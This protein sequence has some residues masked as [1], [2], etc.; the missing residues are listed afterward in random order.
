M[1][2]FKGHVSILKILILFGIISFIAG[3]NDDLEEIIDFESKSNYELSHLSSNDI[4]EI[5]ASIGNY[6]EKSESKLRTLKSA[7]TVRVLDESVLVVKDS[8]ENLTYSFQLVS[9]NFDP[10][11]FYNLIVTKR[12]DESTTSPFVIKYTFDSVEEK[13]KYYNSS[14]RNFNGKAT[15][16]KI[17]N[18]LNQYNNSGKYNGE[19]CFEDIDIDSVPSDSSS[20]GGSSGNGG[21]AS[22]GGPA[23]GATSG[24]YTFDSNPGPGASTGSVEVGEGSFGT[25][26]TDGTMEKSSKTNK[27][28]EDDCP[29]SDMYIPINML[30]WPFPDCS[31]FEYSNVGNIKGA[32]VLGLNNT[33]V[34]YETVNPTTTNVIVNTI[35]YPSLFFTMPSPWT[36]GRSATLTAQAVGNAADATQRWFESHPNASVHL[37]QQVFMNNLRAQMAAYGGTVST[38]DA[39]T[40]RSPAPYTTSWF[41]KNCG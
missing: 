28:N 9:E 39:F 38:R 40:V 29:D 5:N 23:P 34:A 2:N 35:T 10:K 6:F 31:S 27:K 15:V 20:D 19:P 21:S 25:F 16:F 8:A 1:K 37:L 4:P 26:G 33:F 24:E 30:L 3:C 18:F 11:D 17:D 32:K 14:K 22:T 36:N 41:K 12:I 13:I 7:E